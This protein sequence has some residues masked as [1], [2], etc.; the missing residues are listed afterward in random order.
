MVIDVLYI[1]LLAIAILKGFS[2]GL[3]VSVF[4]FVAVIIGLIAA[5]KLSA[6]VASWLQNSTKVTSQWLPFLSFALV[7]IFVIILIKIGAGL[8]QKS[9]EWLMMGWLNRLGGILLYVALYTTVC[10]AVVFFAEKM[11]ILQP[12]TIQDSKCYAFIQP[13]APAMFRIAGNIIPFCKDIFAQL[14]SFFESV[15]AH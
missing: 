10:S 14:G 12:E 11:H 2:R 13:W 7:M 9:A 5:M 4:S 15:S 8:L 6:T 3:I 1:V